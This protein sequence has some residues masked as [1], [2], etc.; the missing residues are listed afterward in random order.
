MSDSSQDRVEGTIDEA[1]GR[2]KAAVG[3]LTGDERTQAE[4]EADQAEGGLKQ[5]LADAKDKVDEVV[6]KATDR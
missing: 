3:G 5:G 1:T 4:G 2:G 6:K